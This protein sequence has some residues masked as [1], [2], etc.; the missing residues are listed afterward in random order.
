MPKKK[1]LITG[2]AGFIG[3]HLTI[4]LL[5]NKNYLIEGLDNINNYYDVSLKKIRLRELKKYENFKFYKNDLKSYKTLKKIFKDAKYEIII[6]LA[7]QAGVRYSITNP[8]AYFDSNINGFYNIL[9]LSTEFKIK[10]LLF[11]STSSVYGN[12]DKFPL[13]EDLKTDSPKSFYSASKKVN[14]IMAYSFSSIYKLPIT[15]LRFFTVYGNLGRPDMALFKFS[16]AIKKNKKFQ[17]FNKGDHYRD[18]THV[19]DVT[20]AISKIINQPPSSKVPYDVFN[21][22]KSKS[23]F[24][25]DVV[26]KIELF[27]NKK[28]KIINLPLQQG[29]VK[30]TLG[31]SKKLQNKIKYKPKKNFND[32]LLE[33]LKWHRDFNG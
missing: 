16:K 10:H 1:I 21:I 12:S 18:F 3:Y 19:D 6:N 4:K 5:K 17:L 23:I 24:I 28:A 22:C 15:G 32:G 13:T 7:A 14:E 29:D 27:Y 8:D 31:S 20:I 25:K 9:K 11:A 30:K 26:K 2:C 33:F